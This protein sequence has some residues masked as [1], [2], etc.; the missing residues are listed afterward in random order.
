MGGKKQKDS[1][2]NW[3][4]KNDFQIKEVWNTYH[5][6]AKWIVPRLQAFKDL[7]EHGYCPYF[8][9]MREWNWLFKR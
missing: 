2:T 1:N 5:T 6:I 4:H 8:K 9:D 3:S 7:D